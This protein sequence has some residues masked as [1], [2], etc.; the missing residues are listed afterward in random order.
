MYIHIITY[1]PEL[2]ERFADDIV[3]VSCRG[4]E[5]GEDEEELVD[6]KG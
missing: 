1:I 3:K 2:S 6:L 4:V 5:M